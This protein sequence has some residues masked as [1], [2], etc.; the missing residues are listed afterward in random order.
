M[1]KQKRLVIFILMGLVLIVLFLFYGPF[2]GFRLLW[3]NTAMY[4]SRHQFLATALYPRSYIDKV[5]EM[6]MPREHTNLQPPPVNNSSAVSLSELKGDYYRGYLI[7]ID[8]PRRLALVPSAQSEGQYLEDMVESIQGLGGINGSGYNDSQMRGIPWGTL[9]VNG[10]LVFSC[11]ER[12]LHSVGGM[13]RAHQLF[14]GRLNDQ[15]I[16]VFMGF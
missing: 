12:S 15:Q 5:L 13:T 16:K 3:I 10:E 6:P 11:T 7:K 2:K 4:S 14:V 8:D 9:I 1:K